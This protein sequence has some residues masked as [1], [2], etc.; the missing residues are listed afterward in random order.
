MYSQSGALLLTQP[1][2]RPGGA[3]L[4]C[5]V[6]KSRHFQNSFLLLKD[7]LPLLLGKVLSE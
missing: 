3:A 1:H 2:Q 5:V 6:F 7:W 4:H